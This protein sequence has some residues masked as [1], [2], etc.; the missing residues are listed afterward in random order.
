MGMLGIS[1]KAL[2]R[3]SGKFSSVLET[4]FPSLNSSWIDLEDMAR[5]YSQSGQITHSIP[6]HP[7]ETNTEMARM[8]SHHSKMSPC[9]DA[10][11]HYSLLIA[12]R[13]RSAFCS[14]Y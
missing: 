2:C 1:V 12:C 7:H 8:T 13:M 11:V 4:S 14:F 9:P 5:N 10:V 3:S 6:K